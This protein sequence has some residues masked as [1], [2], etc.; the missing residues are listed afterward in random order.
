M[1]SRMGNLRLPV[2][3]SVADGDLLDL[4][5]RR[6]IA[7]PPPTT[8]D[9]LVHLRTEVRR[10]ARD[11]TP[12]TTRQRA[13]ILCRHYPGITDEHAPVLQLAL[14]IALHPR[15]RGYVHGVAR[16]HPMT[17]RKAFSTCGAP[18]RPFFE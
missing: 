2:T 7:V 10:H 9:R 17:H 13:Q 5:V 18:P 16:K 8:D 15:H 12:P 4:E 1:R 14:Q 6:H 11:V 3:L